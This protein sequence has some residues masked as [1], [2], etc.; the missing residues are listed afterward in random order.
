VESVCI[1]GACASDVLL[2]SM[3]NTA[4]GCDK[5]RFL[6]KTISR[7]GFEFTQLKW[8]KRNQGCYRGFHVVPTV[9]SNTNINQ[10]S[11]EIRGFHEF[12]FHTYLKRVIC[13]IML[14]LLLIFTYV[15][16]RSTVDKF[17]KDYTTL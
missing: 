14:L 1:S 16:H 12:E 4:T 7:L 11:V 8:L 10:M 6:D 13:D 9:D 15:K 3:S 2:V 17:S 5:H